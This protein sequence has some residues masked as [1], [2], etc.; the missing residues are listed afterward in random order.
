M[1]NLSG[2]KSSGKTEFSS[3]WV[4]K[5]LKQPHGMDFAVPDVSTRNEEGDFRKLH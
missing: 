3:K 4:E 2:N 1:F 5:N